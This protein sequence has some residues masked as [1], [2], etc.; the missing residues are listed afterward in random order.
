MND[1]DA[2][3]RRIDTATGC[4][5]CGEPLRNSPS[6]D[7]CSEACQHAWASARVHVDPQH[8]NPGLHFGAPRRVR[9]A[10]TRQPVTLDPQDRQ[11]LANVHFVTGPLLPPAPLTPQ[12][13]DEPNRP[14]NSPID[15]PPLVFEAVQVS[16]NALRLLLGQDIEVPRG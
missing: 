10:D 5:R 6:D 11:A 7:F 1:L 2:T 13:H 4:H 14:W 3:L 16:P 8:H 15:L 12:E 9:Y